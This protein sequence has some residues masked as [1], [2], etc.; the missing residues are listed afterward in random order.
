MDQVP[1]W[2]RAPNAS[3]SDVRR[4]M[5]AVLRKDTRPEIVLRSALHRLGLRFRKDCRPVRS[6]RCTADVVFPREKVCVFVDG[7]FWHG[8]R[9]HLDAP[10][11]N[12]EWWEEKIRH[13]ARRDRQRTKY[14]RAAGWTVIRLW[15]HELTRAELSH[16]IERVV[17]IVQSH[18]L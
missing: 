16:S 4:R 10:K 9:R 6:L 17:A 7:C 2:A 5:Q 8:C 18:R 11:T 15:E 1:I 14:L 12:A 3:S 13:T